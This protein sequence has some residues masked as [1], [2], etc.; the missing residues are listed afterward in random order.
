MS[1]LVKIFPTA[2]DIPDQWNL[3]GR[4]DQREYLVG[5]ELRVWPGELN[6]IVSPIYIDNQGSLAPTIIGSTPLL[7]EAESMAAL[8]AAVQAYHNGRGEDR[9]SV[10]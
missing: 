2:S 3:P 1:N 10:V 9:K 5:G 6:D 4:I 7:G 8:D